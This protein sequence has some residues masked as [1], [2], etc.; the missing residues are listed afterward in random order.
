M[1]FREYGDLILCVTVREIGEDDVR[2]NKS[3]VSYNTN[4]NLIEEILVIWVHPCKCE[5]G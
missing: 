2:E 4:C 1:V 5:L 3:L